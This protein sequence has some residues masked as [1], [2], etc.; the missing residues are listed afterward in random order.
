MFNTGDGVEAYLEDQVTGVF[1]SS[2][3]E[4]AAAQA[5]APQPPVTTVPVGTRL[6]IRTAQRTAKS[7]LVFP[8]G[9]QFS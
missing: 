9:V 2:G 3:V 7:D 8:C 6:V 5:N 4:T 1:F